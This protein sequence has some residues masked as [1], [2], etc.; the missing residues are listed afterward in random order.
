MTSTTLGLVDHLLSRGR[1]FQQ[2]GRPHDALRILSRLAG[3]RELPAAVAVETQCR[4]GELQ[5]RHKRYARARRHLAA[6]LRFD[7]DNTRAHFLMAQALDGNRDAD[8]A[9]AADHYR[10]ALALDPA[11]P[12]CLCAFGALALRL[13][14]TDEGLECLRA[15]ARLAPD[16]LVVLAKVAAALRLAGRCEE[17]RG[18]LLAA[19]F[20]HPRD[21]RYRKLWDEF[22]FHAAR[23]AQNAARTGRSPDDGPVILPFLRPVREAAPRTAVDG[24]IIRADGQSA[25]APHRGQAAPVRDRRQAQ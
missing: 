2:L 6:A 10:A 19:R 21:A 18:L 15:A 23:G 9:R 7:P 12:E 16:D 14:R 25:T 24:K 11:Q 20:R 22:Q 8:P 1:H 5:L 13:N 3:F 17:A 4:L